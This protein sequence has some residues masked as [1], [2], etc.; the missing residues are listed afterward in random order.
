MRTGQARADA[1]LSRFLFSIPSCAPSPHLGDDGAGQDIGYPWSV[2]LD[3]NRVLTVY[4][5]NTPDDPV[6]RIEG[7]I[8]RV[9]E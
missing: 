6:R 8:V 7:T 1:T 9:Q 5:F 2:R 4:Y 3:A